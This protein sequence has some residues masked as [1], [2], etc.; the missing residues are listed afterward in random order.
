[1]SLASNKITI[2]LDVGDDEEEE[3]E[4]C[5]ATPRDD[6]GK[7][8]VE[9]KQED[10]EHEELWGAEAAD[11]KTDP[12]VLVMS[13]SGIPIRIVSKYGATIYSN[14]LV[15]RTAES[16]LA[17]N[18]RLRPE[19]LGC[20]MSELR[21][22]TRSFTCSSRLVLS[23]AVAGL[24]ETFEVQFELDDRVDEISG[25]S[26]TGTEIAESLYNRLDSLS[27]LIRKKLQADEASSAAPSSLLQTLN[28]E[29][30]KAITK[31]EHCYQLMTVLRWKEGAIYMDKLLGNKTR[32][33]LQSAFR[34]WTS[35]IY[36]LNTPKM[37]NDCFRW[38]LH[39]C[40]NLETDLQAW[41]HA[42][43]CKEVYRL[44][45]P[46][47]FRDAVLPQYRH[48]C[49]LVDQ[50]LTPLEEAALAHVL[51][52][53]DT[54][55]GDVAGQMMVVQSIVPP[56]LYTLFQH[57]SA[58]GAQIVKCPRSGRPAKKMF[59]F[60]FVEGNIYLTWRGKFGNQ[61]VDLGDVSSVVPGI[62]TDVMRRTAE[63]GKEDCYLSLNSSGRSV[64]LCF[65]DKDD[66]DE[67]LHLLSTLVEKEKGKLVGV[68]LVSA[69]PADAS[70]FDWIVLY[71]CLG[72][73]SVPERKRE[74][75]LARLR[76]QP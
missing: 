61:G 68:E 45:G 9:E 32:A 27:H 13:G 5:E 69:L 55:Y 62:T 2:L 3:E 6:V 14:L 33:M 59:R 52:S 29:N 72:P 34:Q 8:C 76:L 63:K 57:L 66:R 20:D 17:I 11:A 15:S 23:F 74:E 44:R 36:L 16:G 4:E 60:S 70:D 50:A 73:L 7:R 24:A 35:F 28:Q 49:D 30:F 26:W 37:D 71:A 19:R 1:M 51:C 18:W 21:E 40:T 46:F 53:P 65:E 22:V 42:I 67:W 39:A 47:W 64:D 48:S 12:S 25:T 58:Q 31:T 38:R 75:L 56:E 54:T 41:Y 10:Q 43:F